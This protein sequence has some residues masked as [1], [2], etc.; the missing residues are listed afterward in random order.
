MAPCALLTQK[1]RLGFY[2]VELKPSKGF[3]I[4][5]NICPRRTPLP[6]RKY[7][8][9]PSA[10]PHPAAAAVRQRP[11]AE[12]GG[13]AGLF[14]EITRYRASRGLPYIPMCRHLNAVAAAH[15][16]DLQAN[17]PQGQC[18]GHSWSR[19]SRQWS[20]CCYTDDHAQ[21]RCVWDKPRELSGYRGDGYE[22]LYWKEGTGQVQVA[23][24]SALDGWKSSSGHHAIIINAGGWAE[25]WRAIGIA[26]DK[27]YALAWFGKEPCP[28]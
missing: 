21:A 22:I 3:V 23:P 14:D 26:V 24:K 19:S 9:P 11:P 10:A 12:A 2:R 1:M 8:Q 6:A 7:T 13:I 18:N 25:P 16:A 17:P 27:N 20:G 4:D 15:V 28:P 5:A